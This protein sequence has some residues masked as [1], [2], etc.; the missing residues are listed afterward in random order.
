MSKKSVRNK[1]GIYKIVAI[2]AS[3]IAAVTMTLPMV[4]SAVGLVGSVRSTSAISG[5]AAPKAPKNAAHSAGAG[6]GRVSGNR[7]AGETSDSTSSD[8]HID[9]SHATWVENEKRNLEWTLVGENNSTLVLRQKNQNSTVDANAL[10]YSDDD[11]IFN[12]TGSFGNV[13]E[14]N[15]KK[16]VINGKF[17]VHNA[18]HM[19]RS[20]DHTE[21]IQGLEN[22]EFVKKDNEPV[23]VDGMFTGIGNYPSKISRNSLK[24]LDGIENWDMKNVQDAQSLFDRCG[25]LENLDLSGWQ[26]VNFTDIQGMFQY[27]DSLKTVKLFSAKSGTLTNINHLFE[28]DKNLK[29][30]TG[31]ENWDTRNVTNMGA[32]FNGDESLNAIDSFAKWNTGKVT[33]MNGM[34]ASAKSLETIKGLENW[35]TKSVKDI[36]CMFMNDEALTSIGSL[37][38]WNTSNVIDMDAIFQGAS[39]LKTIEGLENWNTSNVK[40][41]QFMFYG[42]EALTSIG[43]LAK[44]DTSKVVNMSEMFLNTKNLKTI[45]G[46]ENWDTRSVKDMY[47]MFYG[48]GV[49]SLDLR[50]WQFPQ[51]L[52]KDGNNSRYA[53]AGMFQDSSLRDLT[54]FVDRVGKFN[55][56]YSI[57]P[58]GIWRKSKGKSAI[59]PG[60]NIDFVTN[61]SGPDF[62]YLRRVRDYIKVTF[63]SKVGN[64]ENP[65][66]TITCITDAL[67]GQSHTLGK[68]NTLGKNTEF[69]NCTHKYTPGKDLQLSGKSTYKDN[70]E[71]LALQA[72]DLGLTYT[73]KL[74]RESKNTT[75]IDALKNLLKEADNSRYKSIMT[76][77]EIRKS[78]GIVDGDTVKWKQLLKPIFDSAHYRRGGKTLIMNSGSNGDGSIQIN[79]LLDNKLNLDIKDENIKNAF[80]LAPCDVTFTADVKHK[81][82]PKPP[83]PPT[84]PTPPEPEPQPGPQ[85][86]PSPTP[87]PQPVP[88]PTPTPT[89][90][91]EPNPA[92]VPAPN[93]DDSGILP[94]INTKPDLNINPTPNQTPNPDL[95]PTPNPFDS[96]GHPFKR[97]PE[98]ALQNPL[99]SIQ[100]ADAENNA[101]RRGFANRNNPNNRNNRTNDANFGAQKQLN[102][103]D[104]TCKCVCPTSPSD[105]NSHNSA[106]SAKKPQNNAASYQ[107]GNKCSWLQ[108]GGLVA[109]LVAGLI[110]SWLI[111]LLI[112]F[113]LGYKMR[114]KRDEKQIV[115]E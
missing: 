84:P 78:L 69:V 38:K 105:A 107:N 11:G 91:P 104:G 111:M 4:T 54:L 93:P 110:V 49:E 16:I 10:I 80:I 13:H 43:S 3:A 113:A 108:N 102:S 6:S 51:R 109:G 79:Y 34:F 22:I 17:K 59:K 24:K 48:S 77:D 75:T 18:E 112:G 94:G 20:F 55:R 39:R 101:L 29:S 25:K 87:T 67:Q 47:A 98:N 72:E 56:N 30:V 68:N 1:S 46:V 27:C 76:F 26:N 96:F 52:V 85:P 70:K 64:A 36:S 21:L 90:G 31:F 103:S 73:A 57:F 83:V 95:I 100:G 44:W 65:N 15:I 81:P 61:N 14:S 88:Q 82:K 115:E 114:K 89:P 53:T 58:D 74:I 71:K 86:G 32:M 35:D 5:A 7:A 41:M 28:Y 63:D 66:N 40:Y 33:S 2:C 92:P 45:A 60:E 37:A 50:R 23:K 99:Q 42:D 97:A 106:G 19:F 8:N 9:L 12:K 62:Y